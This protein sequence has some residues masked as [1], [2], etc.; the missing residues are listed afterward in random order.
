M[1]TWLDLETTGLN[2]KKDRILE[3]SFQVTDKA[4]NKTWPQASFVIGYKPTAKQMAD[5]DS[6]VFQMHTDNGLW[7]EAFESKLTLREVE[8]MTILLLASRFSKGEPYLCGNGVHYDR[9]L[10]ESWMPELHDFFHYRNFDISSLVQAQDYGCEI[11]NRPSMYM[12]PKPTSHR[13]MS[14]V[15]W[16]ISAYKTWLSNHGY[17][18]SEEV[19]RLV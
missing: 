10:L 6:I 15:D 12:P 14:D 9:R 16:N 17:Y 19:P 2:P 8:R 1:L 4:G 3:L 7:G 5:I 18:P 11:L 13:G